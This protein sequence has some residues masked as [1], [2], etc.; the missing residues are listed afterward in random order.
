MKSAPDMRPERE[1]L[2]TRPEVG[3]QATPAQAQQS[4][5]GVH[6]ERRFDGSDVI[7]CL[8]PNLLGEKVGESRKGQVEKHS[9]EG[10]PRRVFA[11]SSVAAAGLRLGPGQG[12]HFLSE[13]D[14][15]YLH[16]D[17]ERLNPN[18][19]DDGQTP[20]P[21]PGS[22][23]RESV[24]LHPV[25]LH[26]CS[27]P[28][29]HP[30]GV[31]RPAAVWLLRLLSRSV[32]FAAVASELMTDMAVQLDV[33]VS[34]LC[35]SRAVEI[36]RLVTPLTLQRKRAKIAKKKRRIAKAKTE[37]AEYQKLLASRLKEQREK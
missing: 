27:S 12:S 16:F 13:M 15:E 2:T 23:G 6:V 8:N 21:P 35:Y 25:R 30:A 28:V 14:P 26:S 32:D 20:P 33:T 18:L 17:N 37:A 3:S 19:D 24:V 34:S 4:E 10:R 31:V 29:L 36:Q 5:E 9:V 11:F 7:L 1:T 22:L